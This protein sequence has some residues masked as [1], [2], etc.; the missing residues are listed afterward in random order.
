VCR[1]CG[2]SIVFD[3]VRG[4][5]FEPGNRETRCHPSLASSVRHVP[6]TAQDRR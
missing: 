4:V 5:W 6:E 1:G 2:R 3:A